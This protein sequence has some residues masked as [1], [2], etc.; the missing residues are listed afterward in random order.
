M[1]A[2]QF[3]IDDYW[4]AGREA[5]QIDLKR[6]AGVLGGEVTKFGLKPENRQHPSGT[7]IM[8][9]DP[10]NSVVDEWCRAHD[11]KNLFIAG[12]SVMSSSS[13]MNPT[14]TAAAL[15]IRIADTIIS[16]I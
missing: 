2:I 6:I 12:T 8:G 14:L 5:A 11:H 15:S 4:K 13:C 10:K 3:D 9:S 7:T 1:P 16:E